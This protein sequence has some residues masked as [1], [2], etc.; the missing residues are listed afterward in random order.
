VACANK[1][2]FPA[3]KEMMMLVGGF[4]RILGGFIQLVSS[5]PKTLVN[6]NF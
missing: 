5:P 2:E 4:D 6:W 1:E 3:V